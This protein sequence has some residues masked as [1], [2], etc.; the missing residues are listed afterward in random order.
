MKKKAPS[1]LY[2][3]YADVVHYLKETTKANRGEACV[4]KNGI[5][6]TCTIVHVEQN[7]NTFLY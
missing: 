2:G 1:T 6:F 4:P 7:N 3:R 5:H